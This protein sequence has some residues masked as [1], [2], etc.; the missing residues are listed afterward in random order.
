M[1]LKIRSQIPLTEPKAPFWM[2][3][4]GPTS[5]AMAIGW[6]SEYAKFPT[7]QEGWNATA[8][9]GRVDQPD[10]GNGTSFA[11][12]IKAAKQFG[13]KH[14]YLKN[15]PDMLAKAKKGAAIILAINASQVVI[16]MRALSKWQKKNFARRPKGHSYGHYV[17]L[18][19]DGAGWLY[20]CPTMDETKEVAVRL[21]QAE[22]DT[23]TLSKGVFPPPAVAFTVV[24]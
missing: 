14:Q 19:H 24:K 4:C 16:P 13:G 8:K 17:V 15:C 1:T 9:A 23:L 5:L 3:D 2:D 20:A 10:K 6:A 12:L 21:T 18:A 22:V 11:Q 7:S